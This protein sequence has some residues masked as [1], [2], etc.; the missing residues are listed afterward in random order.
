M[1]DLDQ[2]Q[3]DTLKCQ[4]PSKGHVEDFDRMF[5]IDQLIDDLRLEKQAL[6]YHAREHIDTMGSG[7]IVVSKADPTRVY[8]ISGAGHAVTYVVMTVIQPRQTNQYET[9][10]SN[11]P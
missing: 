3:R 2:R 7:E 8:Q 4:Y 9:H 6:A 5:D 10:E 11:L 1:T